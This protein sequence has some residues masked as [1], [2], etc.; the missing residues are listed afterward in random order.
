MRVLG[1]GMTMFAIL[2]LGG[3]SGQRGPRVVDAPATVEAPPPVATQARIFKVGETVRIGDFELTVKTTRQKTHRAEL[4][5]PGRGRVWLYVECTLVNMSD[6]LQRVT[7]TLTFSL[8]DGEGRA[9]S[10]LSVA[11]SLLGVGA[12]GGFD[13]VAA[14]GPGRRMTSEMVWDV[15]VGAKGL[16]LVVTPVTLV[17]GQAII[18]LGDI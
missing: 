17:D 18:A 16:E 11:M 1:T 9:Q 2:A 15:A 13:P 8:V 12:E 6:R 14:V 7:E 3:C 4:V 5:G 10:D